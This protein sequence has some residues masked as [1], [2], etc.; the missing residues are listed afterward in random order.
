MG[1]RLQLVGLVPVILWLRH[2]HMYV[3]GGDVAT[4]SYY[5]TSI[6][7]MHCSFAVSSLYTCTETGI[8]TIATSMIALHN[9]CI[10]LYVNIL[11]LCMA[12]AL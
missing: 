11:M 5:S 4:T 10:D 1:M 8:W 12:H 3:Q 2:W 9:S 6:D 7:L